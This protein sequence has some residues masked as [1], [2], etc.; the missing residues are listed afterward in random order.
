MRAGLAQAARTAP[1]TSAKRVEKRR[2]R[3]AARAEKRQ[4]QADDAEEERRFRGVPEPIR[5]G[6]VAQAP[7]D[8]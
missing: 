5:F 7:P 3:S 2:E 6:E 4:R 8:G 1:R